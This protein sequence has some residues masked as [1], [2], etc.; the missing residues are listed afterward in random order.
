MFD[1]CKKAVEEFDGH[2]DAEKFGTLFG[3]LT[4]LI[5]EEVKADINKL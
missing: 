1:K 3:E 2:H 5:G 4:L